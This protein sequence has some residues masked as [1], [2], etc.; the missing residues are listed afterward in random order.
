MKYKNTISMTLICLIMGTSV[1]WQYKSVHNNNKTASVQSMTLDD[2]KDKLIIEKR[3]NDELRS[4][5]AALNKELSEFE[6]VKG[7]KDLYQKNLRTELEKANIIAGLTDVKGAGIVITISVNDADFAWIGLRN[8]LSIVNGLRAA[9]ANAVS[10]NEERVIAMTEIS[11]VGKYIIING[12]P[13]SSDKPF[14]IKAIFEEPKIDDSIK[15][16]GNIFAKME[17]NGYISVEVEKTDGII[18]PKI[19]QNRPS[20]N[21]DLIKTK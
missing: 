1:A 13:M 2:L 20:F 18:I 12:V 19:G 6:E 11:E 16:L 10:V 8:I 3:N 21:F 14:K 5:I 15:M 4:R 17:E 7:S 9:E